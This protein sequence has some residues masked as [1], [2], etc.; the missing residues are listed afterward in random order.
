MTNTYLLKS[1]IKSSQGDLKS[2]VEAIESSKIK[3]SSKEV[4]TLE[5]T[6][7]IPYFLFKEKI[8]EEKQEIYQALKEIILD[9]VVDL[10]E[11]QRKETALIIGTSQTDL[12]ITDA[13]KN[14]L[15]K[16]N[17]QAYFSKKRSIDSYAKDISKDLGLN[18]YTMTLCT[19]CT[20]SANAVLEAR[21]LIQNNIFKYV[22]IVG[23]EVFSSMM[24]SG[25]S[26]MKLLSLTSQKPFD[27]SREGLVLGEGIAAILL[28]KEKS[29]WSVKGGYSN[30]DSA[31]ITSVSQS[32]DEF[33][34]VMKIAL[35]LSDITTKDITALKAHA[36]S[37][38]T[39]D[40]AEANA[41]SNVF[42]EKVVFTALKPYTGHTLGACGALELAIF[43]ESVNQGFIP[44]TI[45]HK[46]PIYENYIPLLEHKK[47]TE[48]IFML[49]YFGF[50]G[51]NTS[52]IIEKEK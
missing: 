40:I 33:A 51:N 12:N 21:N 17:T 47:C 5:D 35:E 36:T 48:G 3:I 6:I 31:T 22:V 11:S 52:L 2:T 50:G 25:F 45:N 46:T 37:T 49:N 32:G 7:K 42:D 28:G 24:S 19:A 23:V 26:S 13:I 27:T 4:P 41:I 29:P 38:P 14:T 9:V 15:Y 43:M 30:C 8:Q 20:S 44:K 16:E 34:K 1:S 10:T 18:D 39:N